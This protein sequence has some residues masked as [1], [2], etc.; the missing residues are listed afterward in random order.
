M[1]EANLAGAQLDGADLSF[2][3]LRN[4]DLQSIDWQNIAAIKLANIAGVKNAPA[5]FLEW[6]FKNGAVEN[7][8]YQIDTLA[9]PRASLCTRLQNVQC[10]SRPRSLERN[11]EY[12]TRHAGRLG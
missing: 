7:A 11:D 3:D 8:N 5:G 1:S 12:L 10:Q 9:Y 6:A 2:A 4:A